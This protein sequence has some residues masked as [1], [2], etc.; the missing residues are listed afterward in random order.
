MLNNHSRK[1]SPLSVRMRK[2]IFRA[3]EL[4]FIK[5]RVKNDG[6][7]EQNARITLPRWQPRKPVTTLLHLV[8]NPF[9]KSRLCQVFRLFEYIR[10]CSI[11][12]RIIYLSKN[13]S[14]MSPHFFFNVFWWCNRRTTSVRI[15]LVY[16]L[17]SSEKIA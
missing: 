2:R 12:Y 5:R 4:D 3:N 6:S 17:H 1:S 10:F 9:T 8:R 7:T 13:S 16:Y 14:H 15:L 11:Q